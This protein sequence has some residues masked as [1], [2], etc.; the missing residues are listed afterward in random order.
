ME[1]EI[2]AKRGLVLILVIATVA[3]FVGLVWLIAT[4]V[5]WNL[6]GFSGS[7]FTATATHTEKNC[8]YPVSYWRE[9]PELYPAQMVI[10][11]EVYMAKDLKGILSDENNN[12]AVE[13]KAQLT[14]VFLNS[15]SGADQSSIETAIFEAFGWLVKHPAGSE[16]SDSEREAGIRLFSVL[17]AYNMGLTGSTPCMVISPLNRTE[18]STASET[19]TFIFTT[20][21]IQTISP[22]PSETPTPTS[23]QQTPIATLKLPTQTPIPVTEIPGGPTSTPIKNTEPPTVTKTSLPPT[24][25]NT[26]KP[27]TPI[28]P[29]PTFPD[30]PTPTPTFPPTP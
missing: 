21:P 25:T 18:I 19:P 16:V 17:E 6:L 3:L 28:P 12:P 8:T 20:T 29:S 15:L 30:T 27:P 1:N 26:P 24:P 22:T 4:Y 5:P 13:I 11:G 7:S 9:H 14:G 2:T 10:G 23:Q